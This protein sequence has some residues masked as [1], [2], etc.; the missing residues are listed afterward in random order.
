MDLLRVVVGLVMTS[1]PKNIRN[2]CLQ[3]TPERMSNVAPIACRC[4]FR[5]LSLAMKHSRH[6]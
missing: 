4:V 3:L 1:F 2:T 5:E 6:R